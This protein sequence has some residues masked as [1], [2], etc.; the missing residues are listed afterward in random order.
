M[1]TLVCASCGFTVHSFPALRLPPT[2]ARPNSRHGLIVWVIALSCQSGVSTSTQPNGEPSVSHTAVGA[3]ESSTSPVTPAPQPSRVESAPPPW[4]LGTWSGKGTA[5]AVKL[6]LPGNQGVQLAW[7]QDKGTHFVGP[8]DANVTVHPDGRV[9]GS[10]DGSLGELAV[11]GTWDG[12][13]ALHVELAAE[14]LLPD[15]FFGMLTLP[16]STP[17]AAVNAT[18]RLTSSDGR[19]VREASVP[20]HLVK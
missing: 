18:A 10:I 1:V 8:V 15:A 11:V 2:G 6:A 4:A 12:E 16:F 20:M 14:K 9:T 19:W 3:P 13:G 5:S 17:T 7:V